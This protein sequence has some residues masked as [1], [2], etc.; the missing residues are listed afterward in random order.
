MAGPG[1]A[2]KLAE[3]EKSDL[4]ALGCVWASVVPAPG[5]WTSLSHRLGSRGATGSYCCCGF[6]R[7]LILIHTP[8]TTT[9]APVGRGTFMID[10]YIQ[11]FH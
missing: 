8:T 7:P 2:E 10:V 9:S 11:G 6:M 4:V 3:E 1:P 5:R